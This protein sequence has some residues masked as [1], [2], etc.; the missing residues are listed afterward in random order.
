MKTK[1]LFTAF[2]LMTTMVMNANAQEHKTYSGVFGKENG[3]TATYSYYE[4]QDGKRMFDGKYTF[5]K[6]DKRNGGST[7]TETGQ[8]KD[9][10]L[11]GLW[12]L[13]FNGNLY[14]T[15]VVAKITLNYKNGVLDGPVH[16]SWRETE[17]GKTKTETYTFQFHE[18]YL[19]GKADKLVLDRYIYSYQCDAEDQPVGIWTMKANRKDAT[20]THCCV[21]ENGK[22]VNGYAV[23]M[24]TGDRYSTT[25]DLYCNDL[26]EGITRLLKRP[27]DFKEMPIRS[28]LDGHSMDSKFNDGLKFGLLGIKGYVVGI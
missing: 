11:E 18:G 22:A 26:L 16:Y 23:K 3:G 13:A 7:Y 27:Y 28:S 17:D 9:D 10:K 21:F 20:D 1:R 2:A 15:K 4:R 8:Y 24:A 25:Y 19:T 14:G 5:K 6:V 12:A